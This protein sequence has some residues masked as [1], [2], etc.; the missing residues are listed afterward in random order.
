V[1]F[2]WIC[3]I[4]KEGV[5]YC[6][7][8]TYL[9]WT[10]KSIITNNNEINHILILVCLLSPYIHLDFFCIYNQ[11][12]LV[13]QKEMSKFWYKTIRSQLAEQLLHPVTLMRPKFSFPFEGLEVYHWDLIPHF[14]HAVLD[15][16]F[17]AIK[18]KIFLS[19]SHY[20]TQ[21]KH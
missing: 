20:G 14:A 3:T 13:L 5:L 2:V 21:Q 4:S 1:S 16:L 17:F 10:Q 15:L 12:I 7:L 18:I 9:F 6:M 19:N 11:L 8:E